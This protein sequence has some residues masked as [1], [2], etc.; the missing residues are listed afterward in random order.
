MTRAAEVT[1]IKFY[2]AADVMR[3]CGV[4]RNTA[5]NM[6]KA[7]NEKLAKEHKMT[8]PGKVNASVFNSMF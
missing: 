1:E 4:G 7:I 5:Y 6:I 8:I 3:I 2:N